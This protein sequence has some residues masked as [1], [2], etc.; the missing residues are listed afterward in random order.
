M[1]L[2]SVVIISIMFA[3]VQYFESTIQRRIEDA[4]TRLS[5][6]DVYQSGQMNK[7]ET[8]TGNEIRNTYDTL[9]NHKGMETGKVKGVLY[10]VLVILALLHAGDSLSSVASVLPDTLKEWTGE[11]VAVLTPL[12]WFPAIIM[13]VLTGVLMW[14]ALRK[15]GTF[16]NKVVGLLSQLQ[17]VAAIT[18][19]GKPREN[20]P[21]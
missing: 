6:S 17:I 15:V 8:T 14:R 18:A 12:S 9:I 16:E 3:F 4:K 21:E 2:A 20:F 13:V 5:D 10:C 7:I 1:S 11:A 19:G